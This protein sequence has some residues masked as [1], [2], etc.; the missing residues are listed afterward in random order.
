MGVSEQRKPFCVAYAISSN[1][2]LRII[3]SPP[4]KIRIGL[5]KLLE[6]VDQAQGLFRIQ[7]IRIARC[8]ASARQWTQANAQAR[9]TS[10]AMVKGDWL[11]SATS[12]C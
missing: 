2:S 4:V 7:F 11:K 3:G 10:Q 8:C 1:R 6:A 9:V 12:I 5:P